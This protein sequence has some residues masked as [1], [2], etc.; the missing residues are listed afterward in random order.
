ML[1]YGLKKMFILILSK[2]L[3]LGGKTKLNYSR[4]KYLKNDLIGKM[5]KLTF[6]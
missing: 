6:F 3:L 4:V 5:D 1:L 2:L